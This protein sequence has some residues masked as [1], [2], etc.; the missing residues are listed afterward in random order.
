VATLAGQGRPEAQALIQQNEERA[1]AI[2]TALDKLIDYQRG[3]ITEAT[4]AAN[5][6]YWV[7]LA[8]GLVALAG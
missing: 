5:Q 8:T 7:S 6:A 3:H 2:D 4:A 1:Q